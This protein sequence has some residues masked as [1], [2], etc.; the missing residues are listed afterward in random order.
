[1]E[2]NFFSVFFVSETKISSRIVIY[3]HYID[4]YMYNTH[5]DVHTHL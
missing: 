2:G 3:I 1:M 4:L 5:M